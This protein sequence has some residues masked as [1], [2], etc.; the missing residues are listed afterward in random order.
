M[1]ENQKLMVISP[2]KVIP[3]INKDYKFSIILEKNKEKITMTCKKGCEWQE[4]SFDLNLNT[5]QI[6]NKYGLNKVNQRNADDSFYFV[7]LQD[8]EV[9]DLKSTKNTK[10]KGFSG[11]SSEKMKLFIN[12]TTV[13]SVIN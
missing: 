10:W 7:L 13:D 11:S 2:D 9:F 4:L 8:S 3:E 5:P 1:N 12:P 6:V